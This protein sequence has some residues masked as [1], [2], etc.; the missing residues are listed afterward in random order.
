MSKKKEKGV[1]KNL[2]KA[3]KKSSQNTKG[4]YAVDALQETQAVL[5]GGF[6]TAK[7]QILNSPIQAQTQIRFCDLTGFYAQKVAFKQQ[8]EHEYILPIQEIHATLTDA[9]IAPNPFAISKVYEGGVTHFIYDKKYSAH[10]LLTGNLKLYIR[11]AG[12]QNENLRLDGQKMV[13]PPNLILYLCSSERPRADSMDIY[14]I[15]I[16]S[17]WQPRPLFKLN[18]HGYYRIA[19]PSYEMLSQYLVKV[20]PKS[21]S[22]MNGS[23][24]DHSICKGNGFSRL[25]NAMTSWFDIEGESHLWMKT[26]AESNICRIQW[27]DEH[28][29]IY[30]ENSCVEFQSANCLIKVPP[31]AIAGR[32]WFNDGK[33]VHRH[34]T[35]IEIKAV[36]KKYDP[37]FGVWAEYNF[38]INTLSYFNPHTEYYFLL[39]ATDGEGWELDQNGFIC[40]NGGMSFQLNVRDELQHAFDHLREL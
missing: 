31:Y 9:P 33:P 23:I 8:G 17:V 13:M 5:N 39:K 1:Y 34:A 12:K 3:Y 36:P 11:L 15:S 37:Y 10:V 18:P 27:K 14:Q 28:G 32:V 2:T 4:G 20:A 35:K 30:Y 25:H 29:K 24:R 21:L 38:N 26:N 22:V 6:Y 40:I 7:S 19:M 16:D